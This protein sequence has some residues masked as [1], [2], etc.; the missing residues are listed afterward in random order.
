[1]DPAAYS[2]MTMMKHLINPAHVFHHLCKSLPGNES[3]SGKQDQPRCFINVGRS[4]GSLLQS[5]FKVSSKR[6]LVTT[7]R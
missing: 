4:D 7:Q 3:D 2:L 1:M 5:K 6:I